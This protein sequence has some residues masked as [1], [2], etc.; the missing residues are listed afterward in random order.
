MP[1]LWAFVTLLSLLLHNR[2]IMTHLCGALGLAV[3]IQNESWWCLEECVCVITVYLILCTEVHLERQCLQEQQQ[4]LEL[5]HCE[6]TATA[7]SLTS[8]LQVLYD[9]Y[10]VR[11]CF[12]LL[13]DSLFWGNFTAIK[14]LG[15]CRRFVCLQYWFIFLFLAA[16]LIERGFVDF[17]LLVGY[18][19][20]AY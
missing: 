14:R 12:C 11:F 7:E 6:L 18:Y 2:C 5:R 17:L 13:C 16:L 1:R 8:Q 19:G 20:P 15:K 10:L 4:H 3:V 9:A